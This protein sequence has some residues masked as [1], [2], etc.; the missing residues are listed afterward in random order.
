MGLS[1]EDGAEAYLELF[2]FL[3]M[4]DVS[5][6]WNNRWNNVQIQE[7]LKSV[8]FAPNDSFQLLVYFDRL[9]FDDAFKWKAGQVRGNSNLWDDELAG[10]LSKRA[11]K[12]LVCG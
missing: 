6:R 3:D 5:A 4:Y 10:R 1:T 12:M 9:K 2:K 11:L 7:K 8:Y